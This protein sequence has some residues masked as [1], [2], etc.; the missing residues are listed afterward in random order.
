MKLLMCRKCQDI[1][2]MQ[3]FERACMCGLSKGRYLKD[4]HHAEYSGQYAVVIGV[5]NDSL[6]KA[7]VDTDVEISELIE[8]CI[9][10]GGENGKQDF[11]AFK[12]KECETLKKKE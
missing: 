10:A 12:M 5:D 9:E 8:M 3:S 7:I 2:K 6:R 1:I 11:T 4:G